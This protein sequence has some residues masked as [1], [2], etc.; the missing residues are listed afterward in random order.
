MVGLRPRTTPPG[1]RTVSGRRRPLSPQGREG[2]CL[3]RLPG[4]GHGP[5]QTRRRSTLACWDERVSHTRGHAAPAVTGGVG[6]VLPA[7]RPG[8]RPLLRFPGLFHSDPFFPQTSGGSGFDLFPT[9]TWTWTWMS[10]L[11]LRKNRLY[12]RVYPTDAQSHV[13]LRP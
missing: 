7:G 2:R 1:R 11:N 4:L 12:R 10:P 13:L 6:G 3:L 5:P 8:R 9:W